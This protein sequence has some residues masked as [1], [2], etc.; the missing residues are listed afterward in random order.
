MSV[1]FDLPEQLERTL[2]DR[3]GDLDRAIKE[4]ALIE[5][6]RQRKLSHV[7]LA[8]ALGLDRFETD[9]LLKRHHVVEG[10]LT[11]EDVEADRATLDRLLGPISGRNS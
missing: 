11:L 6:F 9:A 4:A 3:V 8:Q 5:L 2:R 10:S 7:E 1:T